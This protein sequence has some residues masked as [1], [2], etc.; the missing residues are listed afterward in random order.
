MAKPA[1]FDIETARRIANHV[2]EQESVG[3]GEVLGG[4]RGR[5]TRVSDRAFVRITAN[6]ASAGYYKA[7]EVVLSS[8]N[9]WEDLPGGR[10]WDSAQSTD[11]IF[12]FN[13]TTGLTPSSPEATPY[14]VHEV[15]LLYR[16]DARP[17]WVFS[18]PSA[19][20]KFGKVVSIKKLG[21]ASWTDFVASSFYPQ[22]CVA[23][24][25]NA[26][27]TNVITGTTVLVGLNATDVVGIT[28]PVGLI[29]KAN[30]IIGYAQ[31]NGVKTVADGPLSGQA[32]HGFGCWFDYIRVI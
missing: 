30:A 25:C 20:I 5:R 7:K 16:P 13:G 18:A 6:G 14:Q 27:G 4:T 11:E 8:S 29:T 19:S 32:L 2:K 10:V 31:L 9:A 24:P 12:E 26:D 21:G 23:N 17:L 1:V 15:Q 28:V 22:Y 3:G